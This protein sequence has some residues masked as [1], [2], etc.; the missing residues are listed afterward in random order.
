MM[1]R[2]EIAIQIINALLD[3]YEKSKAFT[4]GT[5]RI[6]LTPHK[7]QSLFLMLES[8]SDR[9]PFLE[10]IAFLKE[11]GIAGYER[12]RDDD[13][14]PSLIY[15]DVD[16]ESIA[17]AY[18]YSGRTDRHSLIENLR[19]KISQAELVIPDGSIKSY[20][21]SV[22][23]K[24]EKQVIPRPFSGA[25]LDEDILKALSFMASNEDEI[26]ERVMS[27][28]L[29]GDS[30]HF[31]KNVRPS[32]LSILRRIRTGERD[33]ELLSAY[34]VVRY[35]E[36]FMFSGNLSIEFDD[37]RIND[38]SALNGSVAITSTDVER[39]VGCSSSNI[40]RIITV[41][42]KA[43]YIH[44]V[45][46]RE[47]DEL[48]IFLGGFFSPA[49]GRFLSLIHKSFPEA[50]YRHTGDIDIGGFRIF[51]QLKALI[52]E[53]TPFMMDEDT[54]ESYMDSA[55]K[56]TDEDYLM[57]LEALLSDESYSEF[58]SLISLMIRKRVR[59]EQEAFL[60]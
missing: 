30:K 59:L 27:L 54:L 52:P 60:E 24:T 4:G 25:S 49:K 19:L 1:R 43:N 9:R 26:M 39:A 38:F 42:N 55:E 35:P 41:E 47:D 13:S 14:Y 11:E 44:L 36:E 32:V 56:I 40:R 3:K 16:A 6:I 51:T 58:H 7:D 33:E 18:V 37:E 28:K 50:E 5:R 48:V 21:Q 29:Y 8:P 31:E 22:L 23:V 15:L 34:S 20:L 12:D 10:A 17:K 46:N 53:V 2:D 45:F 57:S